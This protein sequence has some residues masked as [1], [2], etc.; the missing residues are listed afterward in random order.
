[1][2]HSHAKPRKSK[3][4]FGKQY[5]IGDSK[6]RGMMLGQIFP[7]LDYGVPR[8]IA[9]VKS[10]LILDVIVLEWYYHVT[11]RREWDRFGL[12]DEIAAAPRLFMV[13]C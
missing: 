5:Q 2:L 8:G 13:K 10:R 3:K 12:S 4:N 1:M 11:S 6:P 9:P 7:P